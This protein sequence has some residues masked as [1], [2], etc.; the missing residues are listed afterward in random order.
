M[1]QQHLNCVLAQL[2]STEQGRKADTVPDRRPA[3]AH[4]APRVTEISR[5]LTPVERDPF[6]DNLNGWIA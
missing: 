4:R 6:L 2:W 1:H 5:T 3:S